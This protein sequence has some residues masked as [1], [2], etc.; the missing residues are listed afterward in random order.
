[1]LFFYLRLAPHPTYRKVCFST[2]GYIAVSSTIIT[3][4]NLFHCNPVRGG[5]DHDPALGAKCYDPSIFY[6]VYSSL[7][8]VTDI[9]LVVIPIPILLKLQLPPKVKIGLVVMFAGGIS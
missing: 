8:V 2:I 7:N 9:L 5:W 4:I 1:M 3:L 6:Y